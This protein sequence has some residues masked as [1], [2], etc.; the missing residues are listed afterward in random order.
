LGFKHRDSAFGDSD[1][2]DSESSVLVLGYFVSR[3]S[4]SWDLL[5][6]IQSMG[7]SKLRFGH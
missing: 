5:T 7:F 6:G 4:V 1:I 3:D 2:G